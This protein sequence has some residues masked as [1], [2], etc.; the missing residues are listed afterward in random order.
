MARAP[1]L[2]DFD[3]V[4]TREDEPPSGP[5]ADFLAGQA[6][7]YAAG[8]AAA[9]A[10]AGRLRAE[11]AQAFADMSFGYA[12]AR[13]HVLTALQPLFAAV[14]DGF[15]PDLARAALVPQLRT[16]LMAAA[17]ADGAQ[18]VEII[19]HPSQIAAV[20]AALDGQGGVPL[21][22]RGDP[23][24]GPGQAFLATATQETALDL[25]AMRDAM[26]DVLAAIS[27]DLQPRTEHG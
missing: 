9:E 5:S 26:R 11:I 22:L 15:L 20:A 14:I 10:D 21:T 2:E 23:T 18:P 4:L 16:L 8:Q 13:R 27:D 6:E 25:D 24:L 19:L 1:L 17:E 7:G 12:E 3:D